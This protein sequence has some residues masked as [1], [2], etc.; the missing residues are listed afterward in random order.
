[1]NKPMNF[2]IISVVIPMYNVEQYIE[3]CIRSVLSQS[4]QQFEIICVDDGCTDATIDKLNIFSD[5]RIRI[6]TQKNRGLAA[7]RNTGINASRGLY[8]ALLDSDDFWAPSKLAKHYQHLSR[9]SRLGV[10]YS[11][12]L[13]VDEQDQA[14]GTG[15]FPQ[16]SDIEAETIF[17][18]NPVGNGSAPVIRSSLLREMGRIDWINGERRR[19]YFDENLRQSEDVEFWLRIALHTDWQFEGIDEALSYYR[20]NE[21]GLSANIDDQ[22][23]AWN[24]SVEKN[25]IGHESFFTRWYSLAKAY[26]LRYLARRAIRSGDGLSALKLV[27]QALFT[28]VNIIIHE[29]GRT[30]LTYACA[31]LALLPRR[32]YQLMENAA[33]QFVGKDR[34]VMSQGGG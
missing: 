30:A 16:L 1:M 23:N 17:C 26:Q 7:A 21:S 34:S 13:F 15:Q 29:P 19:C 32:I 24:V 10:S 11:G 14:L 33:T 25:R 3:T 22:L 4:F 8:V 20:V 31:F 6:I 27:H 2:P 12:S 9:N 5:K 28:N 18:R